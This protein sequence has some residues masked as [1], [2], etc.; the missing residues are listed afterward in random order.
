MARGA[1]AR[2]DPTPLGSFPSAQPICGCTPTHAN[3]GEA[4]GCAFTLLY[5]PPQAQR[6]PCVVSGQNSAGSWI[7]DQ[8]TRRWVD[9]ETAPCSAG[10]MRDIVTHEP[11]FTEFLIPR[12]NPALLTKARKHQLQE[13]IRE[14]RHT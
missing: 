2:R 12:I 10:G 3:S 9:Q 1:G 8:G 13:H 14:Q 7:P 4:K 5:P 6:A 11:L